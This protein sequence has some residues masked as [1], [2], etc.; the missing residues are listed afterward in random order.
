MFDP[1]FL[2]YIGYKIPVCRTV[3]SYMEYIQSLP[4]I[5]S[6]QALGLHPNADITYIYQFFF[7]DVSLLCFLTNDMTVPSSG[8]SYLFH[9][10]IFYALFYFHQSVKLFLM[11][12]RYQTNTSAE[13]L[14]IITNI[15]PKES[16]GG[17]GATRESI[18]YDMAEDMLEKL[19]PNYVPHEVSLLDKKGCRC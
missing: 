15:Q 6:P 11:L 13:V 2:F 10:T 3:E 5:D 7:M 12:N 19:P 8:V 18:V 4:T 16:G 9:N 1:S 17:S 14:D